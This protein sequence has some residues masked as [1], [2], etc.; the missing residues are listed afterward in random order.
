MLRGAASPLCSNLA[1]LLIA[2]QTSKR[3]YWEGTSCVKFVNFILFCFDAPEN[4]SGIINNSGR[5][6]NYLYNCRSLQ[7]LVF[8]A[9]VWLPRL[10]RLELFSFLFLFPRKAQ[11]KNDK[12]FVCKT[13]FTRKIPIKRLLK[14]L[15]VLTSK[16]S[17]ISHDF[18]DF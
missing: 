6:S 5:L 11:W 8:P 14:H 15:Y 1:A 3:E 17:S 16:N 9:S 2:N 12:I 4:L 7:L 18:L 13:N 10:F